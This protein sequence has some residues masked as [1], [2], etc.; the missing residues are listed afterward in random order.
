M[1]LL[2]SLLLIFVIPGAFHQVPPVQD[3]KAALVP[4]PAVDDSLRS[5]EPRNPGA[6]Y[7]LA[8]L[9]FERGG[10]MLSRAFLQ[11]YEAVSAAEPEALN[12]GANIEQGIGDRA[13]ALRYRQQLQERFPEFVPAVAPDRAGS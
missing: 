12:L 11:R 5:I 10:L 2:A 9:S 1:N 7:E 3:R 6:L 4:L 13:A 8:W